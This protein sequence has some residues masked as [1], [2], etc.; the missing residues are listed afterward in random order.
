MSFHDFTVVFYNQW[1]IVQG[2]NK[3]QSSLL[4]ERG[5]DKEERKKG[6]RERDRERKRLSAV[7]NQM[8]Q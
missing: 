3:V 1:E 4:S 8:N 2:S 6:D 5:R 7:I